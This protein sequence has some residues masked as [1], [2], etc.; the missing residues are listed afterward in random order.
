[1]VA[2]C[3]HGPSYAAVRQVAV[4]D[5]RSVGADVFDIRY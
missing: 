5:A 1:M 4:S 2:W 3:R